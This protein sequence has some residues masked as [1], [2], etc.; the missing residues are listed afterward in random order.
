MFDNC[1]KTYTRES[2]EDYP[3][4]GDISQFITVLS[5]LT[6]QTTSRLRTRIQGC[7]EISSHHPYRHKQIIR[8]LVQ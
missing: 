3:F 2:A 7:S 8:A 5:V 6:R 4:A 1:E